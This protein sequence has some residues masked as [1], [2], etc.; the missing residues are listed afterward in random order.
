M[1]PDNIF[2]RVRIPALA[3]G[4]AN[5]TASGT[6]DGGAAAESACPCAVVVGAKTARAR[7]GFLRRLAE[8]AGEEGAGAHAARSALRAADEGWVVQ[9][10]PRAR[11]SWSHL[12]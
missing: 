12:W 11:G 4:V 6:A 8:G 10:C 9:A 3:P 7:L 2:E 5:G 1:T